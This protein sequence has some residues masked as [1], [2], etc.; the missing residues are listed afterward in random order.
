MKKYTERLYNKWDLTLRHI[1]IKFQD[2]IDKQK[3]LRTARKRKGG[4][5]K[6]ESERQRSFQHNTDYCKTMEHY[7]Q[8]SKRK[9]FQP[10]FLFSIQLSFK[11][12]TLSDMQQFKKCTSHALLLRK[13]L[14]NEL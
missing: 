6:T 4:Y 8:S 10:R 1:I 5:K 3:I 13:L 14:K 11:N 12:R 9:L 2:S 7:L